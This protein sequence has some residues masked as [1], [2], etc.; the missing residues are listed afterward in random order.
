MAPFIFILS[1]TISLCFA[2][3][4]LKAWSTLCWFKCFEGSLKPFRDGRTV[5]GNKE[6]L[7]MHRI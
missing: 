7:Q 5:S 6:L 1:F 4:L 3:H 2:A